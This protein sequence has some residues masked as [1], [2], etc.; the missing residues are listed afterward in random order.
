MTYNTNHVP[1]QMRHRLIPAERW[2]QIIR[3]KPRKTN[4]Y[5]I[6][7]RPDKALLFIHVPGINATNSRVQVEG[8]ILTIRCRNYLGKFHVHQG[9]YVRYLAAFIVDGILVLKAPK[10]QEGPGS[11]PA[12]ITPYHVIPS[13]T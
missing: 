12:T 8:R 11:I 1:R 4:H 3:Q 2:E 6:V 5:L 13:E 10:E 9:I 7:N